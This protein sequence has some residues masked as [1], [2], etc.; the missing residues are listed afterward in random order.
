MKILEIIA[1]VSTL[2]E[3]YFVKNTKCKNIYAYHSNFLKKAGHE[4][5][6]DF[7]NVSK[8]HNLNFY[9]NFKSDIKETEIKKI[10]EL[11]EVLKT[12]DFKG[13]LVNNPAILEIIK[14]TGFSGK[15]II[16]SGLNIHNLTSAEFLSSIYKPQM[17]NI[18]EEI[19]LKNLLK[20]KKYTNYKIAIDANN[21]P[22]IAKEI[23]ENGIV[24]TIIIKAKFNTPKE[25]T[26]GINSIVKILESPEIYKNQKLPFKN[27]ENSLYK[28]DHFSGEFQNSRGRTFKFLGNV[29]NF[30]WEYQRFF[31]PKYKNLEKN[32]SVPRL[33]LRFTSLDQI[34]ELKKYL[35]ILKNN[36]INSIE[37]G[38]ILNTADLAKYSFNKII[39]KVKNECAEYGI[40]LKLGTPRVLIER[41]FDRVYEYTKSVLTQAPYPDSVVVNNLGYWWSIIKDK[42]IN[43]PIEIGQGFNIQNS[44]SIELLE[45][46]HS[47]KTVDFSNFQGIENIKQSIEKL[48]DKIPFRQITIAGNTR[49]PSSGLC[50]LNR[51]SAILTRLSCTAPCHSGTYAIQDKMIKKSFPIAVD[52]FCRVH[53]FKDKILDL[54]KYIN[55]FQEIGINEFV[56]DFSS[57]PAKFVPILLNKY[58]DSIYNPKYKF[59]SNFLTEEY[60]IEKYLLK[61]NL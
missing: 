52:G 45:S 12:L 9:I 18:T 27:I 31:Q 29:H 42:D 19:Y 32:K 5:L 17:I 7:I 47:I 44:S 30:K 15:I 34:N 46:H 41:D 36:P 39:D 53:M 40:K 57:L 59:D 28:T 8:D 58:L 16:D 51:E 56:I 35:K 48:E 60:G 22:W 54:Y 13:I 11:F 25:L 23:I 21:L 24:D 49:I 2:E 3:I 43:L 1:P 61:N 50:P 10:I 26:E 20:I 6:I 33:N 38:E 55:I 14:N 4:K 37:Y